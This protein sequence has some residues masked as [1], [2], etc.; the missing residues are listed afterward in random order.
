MKATIIAVVGSKKSGKT[1]TIEALTKELT[2]RGYKIATVKHIPEPGFTIDAEGKDT[3]RY[4]QAG[5]KTIITA[6]SE[7]IVTIEK[8]SLKCLSLN[9]ILRRCEDIDIVF[10]EG[11]RKQVSRD[12][13]IYKIVVVKSAEEASEA[14]KDFE[15]ILAFTGPYSTRELGLNVP[16]VDVLK[17]PEG[18][19]DIVTKVIGGKF[20]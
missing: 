15:P 10:I 1:T 19:A 11:F 17:N 20:S 7:E 12:K 16:Y 5:A 2:N 18:I 8:T 6:S 3:W 13:D 4:A 14:I 9:G